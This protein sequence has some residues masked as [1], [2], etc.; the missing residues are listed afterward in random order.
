MSLSIDLIIRVN[1]GPADLKH[2]IFGHRPRFIKVLK[3]ILRIL[4]PVF[5]WNLLATSRI[6]SR[7]NGSLGVIT[8][9]F[10]AVSVAG[11]NI[12]PYISRNWLAFI[13]N[14]V[15]NGRF[16]EEIVYLVIN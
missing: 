15:E 10:M 13:K 9:D 5:D 7:V 8:V 2:R 11:G 1:F 14:V 12:N 3:A 16:S 6:S 4:N